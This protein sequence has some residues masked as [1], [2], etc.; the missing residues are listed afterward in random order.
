[1]SGTDD[2]DFAARVGAGAAGGAEAAGGW[3]DDDEAPEFSDEDLALRFAAQH[4]YTMRH[5]AMWDDGSSGPEQS[6]RRTRR[7][8]PSARRVRF[9]RR[10]ARMRER[11]NREIHRQRED[12][13][14]LRQRPLLG[15]RKGRDVIS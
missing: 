10:S 3:D 1:M 11:G 5:V 2:D 13:S 9:A 7:G 15:S 14:F 6:G 4:V 8:W 12:L